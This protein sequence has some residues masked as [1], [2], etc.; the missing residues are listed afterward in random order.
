MGKTGSKSI[1]LM[2]LLRGNPI[3]SEVAIKNSGSIS[4]T[5]LLGSG[6]F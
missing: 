2:R 4:H 5:L 3:V 1:N 6:Y